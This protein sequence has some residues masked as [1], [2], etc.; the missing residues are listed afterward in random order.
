MS[1]AKAQPAATAPAVDHNRDLLIQFEG[2]KPIPLRAAVSR[3]ENT[4]WGVLP[5]DENGKRVWRRR[6]VKI[7][8]SFLGLADPTAL[9]SKAIISDPETG[10]SVEVTFDSTDEAG[11]ALVTDN[12]QPKV[13]VSK[14]QVIDM[15][16]VHA[17]RQVRGSL[18][19][20]KD[21]NWN[22][23]LSATTVPAGTGPRALGEDDL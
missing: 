7:S 18:S 19:L 3:G 5:K 12:G 17:E 11:K 8:A 1:G 4:Y 21:G 22:T 23:N 20:T 6:G 9:P 16:G 13:V 10:E 2:A 15:P 14:G